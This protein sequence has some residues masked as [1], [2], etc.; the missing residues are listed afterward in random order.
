MV[1]KERPHIDAGEPDT[2]KARCINSRLHWRLSFRFYSAG[3]PHRTW[4]L[5]TI[6]GASMSGRHGPTQ[7]ALRAEWQAGMYSSCPH[8]D[9]MLADTAIVEK[10]AS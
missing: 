9:P 1:G 2:Y 10:A 4:F 6:A 5:A 7:C 8:R 3:A